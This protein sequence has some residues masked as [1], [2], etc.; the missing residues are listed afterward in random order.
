M[1]RTIER[2]VIEYLEK[3]FTPFDV[4]IVRESCSDIHESL[5]IKVPGRTNN[6]G[7]LLESHM[8]TVPADDWSERAFIPRL[9][10]GRILGEERVTIKHLLAMAFSVLELLESGERLPQTV[11]F[12]AAGDEEH[13]QAGIK[14]FLS[15]NHLPFGR[16]VVGE[17]TEL[18]PVVQHKGTIRWDITVHGRRRSSSQAEL[19][20]RHH[21]RHDASD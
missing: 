2:P 1:E 19:G 13:G 16:C 3:L 15:A 17:P 10:E 18:L 11:W 20:H 5:L 9:S 14:R 6:P 4:E 8:D 21:S 12:L 7:I